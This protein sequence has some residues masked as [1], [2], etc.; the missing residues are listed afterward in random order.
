MT[1]RK[2]AMCLCK[3]IVACT[4]EGTK[5]M[6]DKDVLISDL[7]SCFILFMSGLMNKVP[8]WTVKAVKVRSS[9]LVCSSMLLYSVQG[10]LLT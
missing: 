4:E 2:I 9:P 6:W 10:T 3:S 1:V 5:S 8:H 7:S